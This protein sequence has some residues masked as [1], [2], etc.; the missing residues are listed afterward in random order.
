MRFNRVILSAT[1]VTL[2]GCSSLAATFVG[3]LIDKDTDAPIAAR[4]YVR[5]ES[6]EYSHV[7]SRGGEAIPYDR[8]RSESSLEVH[9]SVSAHPFFAELPSG[10]YTVTVE[11]GKEYLSTTREITL[12]GSDEITLTIPLTRWSNVAADGWYSGETH[13]H[14]DVDELPTLQ[15]AEDL[16][17]TFPLTAWVTDSEHTPALNNKSQRTVP[18]AKVMHIDDTHL[19]WPVN[20]EY[21]IF[22]V[23][24][25]QHTL[26]AVFI[27]NHREQFALPAPPVAPIARVA[28]AQGGF[29][30]LDK[31]NWPWSMMLIPQMKVDL[32]ELANNHMWRTDFLYSDW[33]PEYAKD[34]ANVEMVEGKFTERGWI[35]FG[36]ENYYALLNCGFKMQPTAGSASGV[37]PVP[38]GFGRVYVRVDGDFR[39]EKWVEGLLAGRSFVT[40]G[41]MLATSTERL[42]TGDVRVTGEFVSAAEPLSVEIVVNGRVERTIDLTEV[43]AEANAYHLPIDVR[44]PLPG[45]SWV[46]IRGFAKRSASGDVCFAHTAPV[47]FDV[48][49]R[50]LYPTRRQRDY[51]VMRVRDEIARSRG[52]LHPVAIREFEEALKTYESIE[53][54]N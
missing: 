10:T 46:A 12:S 32:F 16:N 52:M 27:L 35:E 6:G 20:T 54:A 34:L 45:S 44:L 14:R 43:R 21:E 53:T 33:Y 1:L 50:P 17:V 37:H 36:F 42:V 29:L 40:T 9:T 25:R 49:G 28:R 47:Y 24:G 51:L 26:G 4:V 2:L 23:R 19:F 48:A 22:T 5:N 39:Y 15:L 3:V 31:H 13:V 7:K 38:I 18:P 11:K 41:P 30:E 8:R